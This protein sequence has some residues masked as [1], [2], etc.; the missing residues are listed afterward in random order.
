[1]YSMV[2]EPDN[3]P[4]KAK[5]KYMC[6]NC[7]HVFT[8]YEEYLADY[9]LVMCPRCGSTTLIKLRPKTRKIVIGV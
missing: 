4:P 2:K 8:L 6:L 3:L 7:K 1:M 5:S 9:N